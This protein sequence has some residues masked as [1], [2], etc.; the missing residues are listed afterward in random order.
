VTAVTDT[1]R[2]PIGKFVPPPG[3]DPADAATH[4]GTLRELPSRIGAATDGLAGAQL[5]T[6]YRVGGWTV[7]QVVHHVADSHMHAYLR[8]KHA[9]T[10]DVPTIK[11]YDEAM[12]A[13]LPDTRLPLEPSLAVLEGVHRRWVALFDSLGADAWQRTYYHPESAAHWPIWKVAGLYAWHSRHHV[14]HITFLREREG[15]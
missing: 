6:P 14:A 13:E 10:E 2:F 7:R 4:L 15:W 8:T 3:Y 12:W 9:L 11:P 5:D 1:S